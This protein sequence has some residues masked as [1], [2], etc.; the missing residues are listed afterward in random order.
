MLYGAGEHPA[1]LVSSL[2]RAF[3]KGE[4]AKMSSGKPVRDFMDARDVGA[5]IAAVARADVLG[6]VNVASGEPVSVVSVARKLAEL[7]GRPE[8]LAVGALPDRPNEPAASYADTQRLRS[9][10]GFTPSISLERGLAD[11]LDYW[12]KRESAAQ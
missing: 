12:R 2:A 6:C 10:V 7:S 1:R 9:E 3:V 4:S 11:A 8:L 5:G